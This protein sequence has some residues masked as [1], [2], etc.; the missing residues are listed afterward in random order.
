MVS[1]KLLLLLAFAAAVS[2]SGAQAQT[3]LPPSIAQGTASEAAP[4]KRPAKP[5][6]TR[7]SDRKSAAKPAPQ[8]SH[9]ETLP[10]PGRITREEID[11]PY[12]PPPGAG[13]GRVSPSI[14]PSGRVGV[15][16]RF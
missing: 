6:A 4:A 11:D 16:G 9:P 5:K 2:L 1:H 13:G 14:S 3:P 12:G 15:G 7:A 8:R 10:M